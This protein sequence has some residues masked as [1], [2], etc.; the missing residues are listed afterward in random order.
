MKLSKN[1]QILWEGKL[2]AKYSDFNYDDLQILAKID[3][4]AKKYHRFCEDVC[5]G[6]YDSEERE[7]QLEES[8]KCLIHNLIKKL[9]FSV[10]VKFQNDPRGA[11]VK[12]FIK[13]Y[14]FYPFNF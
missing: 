9:S 2:L 4:L 1:F 5:N 14:M 8:I 12:L 3:R 6:V 11:E 7:D 10:T 13:D